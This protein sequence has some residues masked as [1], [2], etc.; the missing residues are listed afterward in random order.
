[1]GGKL[2]PGETP[3]SA[4]LREVREETGYEIEVVHF[5]GA[6]TWEPLGPPD[7]G[8]YLYVSKAPVGEPP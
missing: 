8:I 3:E 1:M 5:V 6:I 4:C 7:D 2:H